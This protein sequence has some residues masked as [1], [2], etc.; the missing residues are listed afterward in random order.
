MRKNLGAKPY[1]Y[2]QPVFMI[3]TYNEDGTCDIMNAAWGGISDDFQLS[4]CLAA[5]HKTTEN[6][7][8]RK[9]Y[10][11]SM[12]TKQMMVA[13]DYVGIDSGY[14]VSDKFAKAGFS[15]SA[16][17]FVDAPLVN[18]LPLALECKLVSYDEESCRLI[19]DIVNVSVDES[20]LDENGKLDYKKAGFITFDPFNNNYIELGEVVGKAFHDGLKLR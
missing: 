6:I 13:C 16:S 10:T 1:C 7:I 19:G 12:A 20:I 4:I 14:K 3:A 15:A 2:P 18:E 8:K 9:A 5:N 11:V 17:E